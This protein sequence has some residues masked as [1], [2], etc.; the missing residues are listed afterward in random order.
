MWIINGGALADAVDGC[1]HVAP[2]PGRMERV[3]AGQSFGVIVDYAHT[4]DALE[5]VLSAAREMT[6][7]GQ[8]IVVVGCGGDRD[9][10]KRPLMGELAA[11]L[12]D[13]A[14]I[15]SDNPRSEDP[16][17]IADAMLAGAEGQR[18]DLRCELDRRAAIRMA[19]ELAHSGDL[20]VIAGKGH[21]TGQT[22][23]GVTLAFDD[24]VVAREVLEA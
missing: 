12:S 5:H 24:R 7:E 22:I 4:P 2:V 6:S 23:A 10:Q 1:A 16:Q 11:K 8:V 9:P 19:C 15:T 14:I 3:D 20:V 21:E 13:V 17:A 18:S